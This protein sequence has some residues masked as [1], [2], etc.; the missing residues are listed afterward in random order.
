[1]NRLSRIFI[2]VDA[3]RCAEAGAELL[4]LLEQRGKAEGFLNPEP[5]AE[6]VEGR[7]EAHCPR[8]SQADQMQGSR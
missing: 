1:M 8:A 5:L 4:R 7:R 6:V 2:T 3:Q